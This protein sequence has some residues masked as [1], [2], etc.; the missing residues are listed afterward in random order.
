MLTREQVEAALPPNLKSAATQAYTDMVNNIVSDPLIADQVRDNFIGYTRVLQDGAFKTDD[1]LHA[2]TYVSFKL[3]GCGNLEAYQRT[4]PN[5]YQALVAKGTSGKDIAGYVAAYHR[6]KLVGKVLE[7]SVTPSW[8]LNQ[9]YYQKA[10]N[11]QYDLMQNA[12]SEKV[13]TEAA[14]S[15]LTHLKQPEAKTVNLNLGVQDNSGL[16]ELKKA[17]TDLASQQISAIENGTTTKQIASQRI[18]EA[19]F[20]EV[21]AP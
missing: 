21:A 13:R 7:Q 10:L 6:G 16:S 5:R 8:V 1:Y 4:F 18:I 2:V 3:M 19:E 9:D 11:V 12:Q 14:N 17:L 15:I 20:T